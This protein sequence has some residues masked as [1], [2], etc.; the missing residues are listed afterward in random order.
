MKKFAII[1]I[2][3][4]FSN[5]GAFDFGAGRNLGMGRMPLFS[6]PA[7]S[8]ALVCPGVDIKHQRV[9]IESGFQRRFELKDLDKVY[10][11]AGYRYCF[12]YGAFGFSQFGRNDYYT[13]RQWN[14]ILGFRYRWLA[15]AS[16]WGGK[17]I[18]F[19]NNY[20]KYS[21]S[22]IGFGGGVNIKKVH[23]GFTADNLNKPRLTSAATA[24]QPNLG[25]FTEI[26]GTKDFSMTGRAIFKK[27]EKPSL[28]I[29]QFIRLI[30]A[31]SVFWGIGGNP[32]TY[33]GG[34]GLHYSL[35]LI[36]YAVSFHPVLGFSHNIAIG[37]AATK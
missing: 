7:A 28:A 29:G 24:E 11:A 2:F 26:E 16:I 4:G 18:E 31:N 21:I 9:L 3:L 34:V 14:G 10:A 8:D 1:F 32:L 27:Y 33:G 30:G 5:A 13:E 15:I 25:F 6:D 35:F 23:F 19:G 12:V 37:L 17:N 20:G 22:S 36:N